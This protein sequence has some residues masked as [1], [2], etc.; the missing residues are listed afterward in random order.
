[1]GTTSTGAIDQ[2]D[3]ITTV[4][5]SHPN[6]FIHLDG[7]WAGVFLACPEFRDECFM[8]VINR[9]A[10]DTGASPPRAERS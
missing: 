3:E 9:R 1:M 6:L 4:G 7:A 8:D 10:T 5:A 2:L